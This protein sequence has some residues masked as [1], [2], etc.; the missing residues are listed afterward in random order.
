VTV[1][2]Q[3]NAIRDLITKSNGFL[4]SLSAED[5]AHT[6]SLA[7]KHYEEMR[8]ACI[9]SA[10]SFDWDRVTLDTESYYHSVIEIQK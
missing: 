7:L 4:S 8:A 1:N 10:E 9:E 6:I 2:Y 5:I 3:T